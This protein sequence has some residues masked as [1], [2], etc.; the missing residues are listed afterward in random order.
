MGNGH[1]R[2]WLVGFA[3][4][5]LL[6]GA[7]FAASPTGAAD[8]ACGTPAAGGTPSGMVATGPLI[9]RWTGTGPGVY[10]VGQLAAGSYLVRVTSVQDGPPTSEAG[11][12]P[13]LTGRHGGVAPWPTGLGYD[14]PSDRQAVLD[15]FEADDYQLDVEI[16][17]N[18]AWTIEIAHT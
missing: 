15:V 13:S 18:L 14:A 3:A 17:G 5:V 11:V 6:G 1:G 9:G 2:R 10:E 8:H 7:A 12:F 16:V 4:G